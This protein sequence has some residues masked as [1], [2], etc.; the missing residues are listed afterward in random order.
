MGKLLRWLWAYFQART[1]IV[2]IG[3]SVSPPHSVVAGTPQG[4]VLSPFLFNLMLSDLPATPG[5]S[6]FLYADDITIACSG[7]DM[8][9]IQITLQAYLHSLSDWAR[10]WGLIVNPSKTFVQHFTRRRMPAPVLYLGGHIVTYAKTHMLLGVLFDS[11]RLTW[12][13]HIDYLLKNCHLRLNLLKVF[14][15]VTWG[16]SAVILRRFYVSYI[17]AKIDYGSVLY[18]SAAATYLDR[19]E[20]L[21]NSCMRLILGARNTTPILSLQVESHLPPLSLRRGYLHAVHMHKLRARPIGDTTVELLRLGGTLR[22]QQWPV[23]SFCNR[24]L[25]WM[26]ALQLSFPRA[27][28]NLAGA[29]ST[30]EYSFEQWVF[31]HCP[32][33]VVGEV[34]F[35]SYRTTH[36]PAYASFYTDGSRVAGAPVTVGAAL[37]DAQTQRVH[38]WRL[39]SEHSILSAELYAILQALRCI[40]QYYPNTHSVVYSDSQSALALIAGYSFSTCSMVVETRL[41]LAQLN[42]TQCVLL[43][44]VRS[45]TGIRGNELADLA[46]NQARYN[47]RTA[48]QQLSPQDARRQIKASLLAYWE[49]YWLVTS[50][51]TSKGQFLISIRSHISGE[52]PPILTHSR[53]EEIVL[54]RMRMGH[55]G[56]MSYLH[57]FQM[58]ESPQCPHSSCSVPETVEHLLLDCPA[59]EEQWRVL[60]QAVTN[61]HIPVITVRLLLGGDMGYA[62]HRQA[63]LCHTVSY[64]G[65]I[66][67]LDT[68]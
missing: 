67:R 7:P 59:H 17:R 27:P 52:S 33:D 25:F 60:Q 12:K 34:T 8:A 18:A 49:D 38:C 53:R 63:L 46:A 16:A 3:D 42:S 21:Q 61:L 9:T 40:Q 24:A 28:I 26:E 57:R 2:R 45:H 13:G 47:D 1:I 64:L 56:V 32:P 19:L 55:V 58:E 41:L 39:R 6:R 29:V 48:L 5:M 51:M 20:V 37:Y 30:T 65:A 35:A 36:F 10:T 22:G 43:H 15:S 14:S 44:W 31:L 54:Y 68:L 4:G 11:P 62:V 66:G 50:A 23:G